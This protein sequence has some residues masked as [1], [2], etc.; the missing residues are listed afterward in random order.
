MRI[1]AAISACLLLAPAVSGQA[2]GDDLVR[3][4]LVAEQTALVPGTTAWIGFAFEINEG[5]HLYW[6]GA[7]DSGMPVRMKT[8]LP[9]GFAPAGETV[10]PAPKRYVQPGNILDHIYE[11][12]VTLRL[13]ISVPRDAKPGSRVTLEASLDWLV[14]RDVCLPGSASVALTLPVAEE[15]APSPDAPLFVEALRR[16]PLPMPKE[17]VSIKWSD[18][19]AEISVPGAIAMA[20]YPKLECVRLADPIADAAAKANRLELRIEPKP[21]VEPRLAGVLE[22]TWSKTEP[23]S[24]YAID[25]DREGPIPPKGP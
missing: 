4:R 23:P 5:W 21:G 8:K 6:D 9:A 18:A 19:A 14:C 15:A 7:N 25:S 12:R 11:E 2:G 22:V 20:F 13:P 16:S 24:I 17:G 10:W 1:R 3:A